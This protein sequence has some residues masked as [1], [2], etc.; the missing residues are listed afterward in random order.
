MSPLAY[1]IVFAFIAVVMVAVSIWMAW[2][3]RRAM[4]EHKERLEEIIREMRD[5]MEKD[6]G[7]D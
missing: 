1:F 6:D 5:V 7:G 4:A 2:Y 3:S